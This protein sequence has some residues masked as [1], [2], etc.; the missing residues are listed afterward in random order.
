M[1]SRAGGGLAALM[2]AGCA[3]GASNATPLTL[4]FRPAAG[5]LNRYVYEQRVTMQADSGTPLPP[6]DVTLRIYL[7]QAVGAGAADGIPVTSTIDS[8]SLDNGALPA[9]FL[10]AVEGRARGLQTLT[11]LDQR[12]RTVR[13]EVVN[14]AGLDAGRLDAFEQGTSGLAFPLPEGP[15]RVG[16]SW[17]V[18]TRLPTGQMLPG[19]AG[20]LEAATTLTV[21]Q[22]RIA[23]S[24]TVV[25]LDV[26]SRLP[27][28]PIPVDM[29]IGRS[30]LRLSGTLAGEQEFSVSRGTVVRASM[31]GE[32]RVEMSG[33]IAGDR[34][35]GMTLDQR[36]TIQM[37]EG[38]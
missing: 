17:T 4:R 16:D 37:L 32:I 1:R 28:A 21:R 8:L 25:L 33:G 18:T 31:A 23:G 7:T 30:A 15:V 13:H 36:L 26:E 19:A 29:G 24:D 3:A 9:S 35:M 14:R 6:Q 5:T 2:I 20:P 22:V 11:V 27:E 34:T 10:A 12:M 38:P